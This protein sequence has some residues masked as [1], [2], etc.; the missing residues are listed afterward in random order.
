MVMATGDSQRLLADALESVYRRYNHRRLVPPDPLQFVHRYRRAADREIVGFLAAML[1]YGRVRQ[2]EAA[3]ERLL[4]MMG[5]RPAEFV[6]DIG[7]AERRMLAEFRHRFTAGQDVTDLMILLGR[8]IR[9]AGSL[10]ALFKAGCRDDDATIFPALERF[11]ETLLEWHVAAA[12]GPMSRGFKHLL[13]SPRRGGTCKRLHLFLRWMVRSDAVDPGVWA[14]VAPAKLIVPVDV[15]MA[16]LC[17]LLG[18]HDDRTVCGRTAMTITR[19]FAEIEPT[20]P[21]KYD[22]ALSR[23]GIMEQCDGTV[24]PAC[25]ACELSGLCRRRP[26]ART[27]EKVGM[28]WIH[29]HP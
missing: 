11:C 3:C 10:E 6:R 18:L 8:A 2:I 17:R 1:A 27:I 16:R 25:K 13:S 5:E 28:L 15:H 19:C 14:G 22:F 12:K 21:V 29:G 26:A 24:R 7:P 23:I 20:D 4:A 9:E